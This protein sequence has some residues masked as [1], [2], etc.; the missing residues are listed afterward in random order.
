MKQR[1]A[2][3]ACARVRGEAGVGA[4]VAGLNR[5]QQEARAG[6]H[7]GLVGVGQA[8]SEVCRRPRGGAAAQSH[9][10]ARSDVLGGGGVTVR[11]DRDDWGV[12]AVWVEG[13]VSSASVGVTRDSFRVAR[14]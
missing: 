13:G 3:A 9:V 14:D 6:G 10:A 12:R 2:A 11:G 7:R 5:G 1:A 8:P 4:G